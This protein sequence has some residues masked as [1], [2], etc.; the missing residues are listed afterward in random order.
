MSTVTKGK[1]FEEKASKKLI[2]LYQFNFNNASINSDLVT[3]Q[4]GNPP[5]PHK[6]DLVSEDKSI[7]VEC[8]DNNW[9]KTNKIPSGKLATILKEVLYLSKIPKNIKKIIVLKKYYNQNLNET[10]AEYFVR[11]YGHLLDDIVLMELEVENDN[12]KNLN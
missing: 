7:V 4:V 2:K 6:F 3:F 10:L 9:S 12:L 5:K 1:E 8:K 11:M